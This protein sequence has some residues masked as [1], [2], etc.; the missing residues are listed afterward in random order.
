MTPILVLLFGVHSATAVGTDLLYASAT[1]S[2][3]TLVH[4]LSHTVNWRI[5]GLLAA[6]RCASRSAAIL[7]GSVLHAMSLTAVGQRG[8]GRRSRSNAE[9][10]TLHAM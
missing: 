7:Y 10:G 2:V 4:G 1:K 9:L 6:G 8:N 5:V 3:G